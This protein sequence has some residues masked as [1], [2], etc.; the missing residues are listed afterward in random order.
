MERASQAALPLPC[1]S[2]LTPLPRPALCIL[3]TPPLLAQRDPLIHAS[4]SRN[5]APSPTGSSICLGLRVSL[6]T[7]AGICHV[8]RSAARQRGLPVP[9]PPAEQCLGKLYRPRTSFTAKL[10]FLR[11]TRTCPSKVPAVDGDIKD[12]TGSLP[13]SATAWEQLEIGGTERSQAGASW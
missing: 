11:S 12:F 2:S 10:C 9:D 8:A 4:H 7:Q 13:S 3:E 6:C 5:V 1:S